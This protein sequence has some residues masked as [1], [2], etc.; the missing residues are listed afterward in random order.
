MSASHRIRVN[1][2]SQEDKNHGSC[3]AS[4]RYGCHGGRYDGRQYCHYSSF[5]GSFGRSRVVS[6]AIYRRI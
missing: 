4:L 6:Y 1:L 2:Q 3:I 5:Y